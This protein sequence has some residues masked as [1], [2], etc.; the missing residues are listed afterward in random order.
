MKSQNIL[1]TLEKRAEAQNPIEKPKRPEETQSVQ[2][3]KT[4]TCFK[5]G[6][7]K[8][9]SEYY[10]MRGMADGLLGKCKKCTCMDVREREIRLSK[11]PEWVLSERKRHR[12]KSAKA[13][14]CGRVL[15]PNKEARKLAL[16]KSREKYP[17]KNHARQCVSHAIRTGKMTRKPC[18]K[19]G[20]RAQAHHDDYSKP[21]EVMWLCPKH[22]GERHV[23]LNEI[24]IL[25]NNL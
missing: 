24:K 23:E 9:L 20:E 4:K 19:C 21:L 7:E 16:K 8:P 17:E 13:R 12:E 3:E 25:K 5:C 18:E 2:G 22:H 11:S 6:Q 15:P 1:L 14:A 10:K